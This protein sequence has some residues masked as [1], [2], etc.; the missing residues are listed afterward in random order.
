MKVTDPICRMTVETETARFVS[1]RAGVR[2]YFC[3]AACRDRF[4]AST[5]R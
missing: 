5:P 1:E 4:E 3:S 2:T